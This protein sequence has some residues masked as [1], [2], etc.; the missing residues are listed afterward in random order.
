MGKCSN[1]TRISCPVYPAGAE[2][3]SPIPNVT[4]WNSP[5]K[6]MAG[7]RPAIVRLGQGSRP[8]LEDHEPASA[9]KSAQ[10]S[11]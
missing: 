10:N 2:V 3:N 6:Q 7:T 4:G 1:A 11:A 9:F 8:G 5:R